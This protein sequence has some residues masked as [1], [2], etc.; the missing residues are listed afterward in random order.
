MK[1]S[2]RSLSPLVRSKNSPLLITDYSRSELDE[3][4]F[5]S[6]DD[7]KEIASQLSL[8]R[9]KHDKTK[10][11]NSKKRA[12][13]EKLK[14]ELE[15]LNTASNLTDQDS[16]S[17]LS[18][19]EQ[20]QSILDQNKK[21]HEDEL[22]CKKSYLYMLDRMKQ[23]KIAMEMK[24]NSL[25]TC[26]KSTNYVVDTETDKFRK[27][28]ENQYQSRVM[29]QEIKE[30]LAVEQRRKNEKISQLEKSVRQRQELAYRREER[31]RRQ[32]E[33]SEAAANDDKDS[34]E[35]KLRENILLHRMWFIFLCKRFQ[36]EVKKNQ[37]LEQAY[38]MIKSYTGLSDVNDIVERYLT[39]ENNYTNLLSAVSEAE[40]KLEQLK[41][42]NEDARNQLRSVR[43]EESG[44]TRQI[45]TE[46]DETEQKLTE[47]YKEYA[48]AKE[49]LQKNVSF[50]NTVVNWG[51]K[52]CHTLEI[53][54][55]LEVP[56]G[57]HI[58]EGKHSLE[59]MFE[60]ISRKVDEV[61][62]PLQEDDEIKKAFEGLKRRKTQDIVK[63]LASIEPLRKSKIEDNSEIFY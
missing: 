15:K 32:A 31:Q 35:S 47:Y 58:N 23:E 53:K 21:K 55:K 43:F 59:D 29:L 51:E 1:E 41:K 2:R 22:M 57:N 10:E 24:A 49:K 34:Q 5:N 26:L 52:I 19:I 42:Q 17:L 9:K 20:L 36:N 27:I 56:T 6:S 40:K 46:I 39:R 48:L 61:I 45:Y 3:K 25:Q 63:E 8:I 33:I 13:C 14:L 30:T 12:Y 7:S 28:R 54:E 18:K 11:S 37:P 62:K 4:L 50:Y 16:K 60:V 44:S 38:N